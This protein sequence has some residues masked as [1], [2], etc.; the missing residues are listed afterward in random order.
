M[1]D[2]QYSMLNN[3]AEPSCLQCGQT[4]DRCPACGSTSMLQV[5][6]IATGF[7]HNIDGV[8]FIQPPYSILLCQNC[9][10]YFKSSIISLDQLPD[11]YAR[12]DCQIFEKD[13]NF[14]TDRF[15][16][17]MLLL[18]PPGK[19]VLDYGCSTGRMLAGITNRHICYGI[20]MNSAA[21]KIAEKKGIKIITEDQLESGIVEEFDYILL[22]DV[23][24]HL[25]A[26]LVLLQS[27]ARLLRQ[28]GR[29]IL[30]TGN[31]DAM[32]SHKRLANFWY[33]RCLGHLHMLGER[34][35]SWLAQ[36][37]GLS[38][39][40]LHRCCHYNFPLSARFRQHIQQFAYWQFRT[41]PHGMISRILRILPVMGR[42]E[43]WQE[44]PALTCTADHFV[45]V[46]QKN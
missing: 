1:T 16:R 2:K 15:V 34:H 9:F 41:T 32:G 23:F 5:S 13:G 10:L 20:E 14:P 46:Y 39:E 21:A 45:A 38:L 25:S 42:A 24:E 35:A 28:G 36:R 43:N 7:N 19:K 4:V 30:I 27:Q 26:P 3:I 22:S 44:A 18:T 11:Y 8:P 12:L 31:A 6:D 33:F 17:S 37:L 29:L 40:I